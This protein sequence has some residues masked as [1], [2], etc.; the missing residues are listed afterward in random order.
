MN[1]LI[2]EPLSVGQLRI[3]DCVTGFKNHWSDCWTEVYEGETVDWVITEVQNTYTR[4]VSRMVDSTGVYRRYRFLFENNDSRFKILRPDR[5]DEVKAD[6]SRWNGICPS[7]KL[8]T[9]T[10]MFQV[11]HEGG[12]CAE[13]T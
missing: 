5:T 1:Y 3:G 11:E 10:G 7:C 4:G 8:G 13:K 9:Y 12:S 2:I 6:S